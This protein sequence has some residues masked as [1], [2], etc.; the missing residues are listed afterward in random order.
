MDM[1]RIGYSGRDS[2]PAVATG[3]TE[4]ANW[5]SAC[6]Q[7][8][9]S[10]PQACINFISGAVQ[11]ASCSGITIPEYSIAPYVVD[12]LLL[13]K[14]ED[15]RGKGIV[16]Q[17]IDDRQQGNL[18]ENK[19][20]QAGLST[21]KNNMLVA[22]AHIRQLYSMEGSEERVLA[23]IASDLFDVNDSDVF[24]VIGYR[25]SLIAS[26]IHQK[27]CQDYPENCLRLKFKQGIT[28]DELN[29]LP[30]HL[31][32]TDYSVFR[33][34]LLSSLQT[35]CWGDISTEY[36]SRFGVRK[37]LDKSERCIPYPEFNELSKDFFLASVPIGFHVCGLT[38]EPWVMA[39]GF[40]HCPYMF[41]LHD[42]GH[43]VLYE[44]LR[45][46]ANSSMEESINKERELNILWSERLNSIIK[47]L[48]SSDPA[49]SKHLK[50]V[51]FVQTH[52]LAGAHSS[53]FK[54]NPYTD[55]FSASAFNTL[56]TREDARAYLWLMNFYGFIRDKGG[57]EA[58]QS[59]SPGKLISDFEDQVALDQDEVE[60]LYAWRQL[61]LHHPRGIKD[62]LGTRDVGLYFSH[63]FDCHV[64]AKRFVAILKGMLNSH[65]FLLSDLPQ[66]CHRIFEP[67]SL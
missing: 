19:S 53:L 30:F 60:S 67:V 40:A 18:A 14:V 45:E 48:Y 7:R 2:S 9:V 10:F 1:Q 59:M 26:F 32:K 17:M 33:R 34:E 12:D 61:M 24:F 5:Q 16:N 52:E 65:D 8:F 3:D 58:V 46:L 4:G 42:V 22:I 27:Y 6:W 29:R 38:R 37:L 15:F 47:L 54:D 25:Y 50:E 51:I 28:C 56:E 23:S 64:D 36:P 21:Q 13:K 49:L 35:F 44:G 43:A 41:L 20:F 63:C 62:F 31:M 66:A 55:F 11:S 39:D 57:M